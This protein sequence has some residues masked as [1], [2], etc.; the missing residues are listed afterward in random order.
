MRFFEGEADVPLYSTKRKGTV[1]EEELHSIVILLASCFNVVQYENLK[2]QQL[3]FNLLQFFFKI[4]LDLTV[5][6]DIAFTSHITVLHSSS[7][8]Y[9]R[10]TA[11]QYHIPVSLRLSSKVLKNSKSALPKV[12]VISQLPI[13]FRNLQN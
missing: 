5:F 11:R 1:K 8:Y 9:I 10:A 3:I 2:K 12:M 7:L 13:F 4:S 6:G